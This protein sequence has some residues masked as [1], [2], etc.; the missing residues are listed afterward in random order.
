MLPVAD[1]KIDD[2]NIA[3]EERETI[4]IASS[5][6]SALESALAAWEAAKDKP[7]EFA[8]KFG[9]YAK[10]RDSLAEWLTLMLRAK[11]NGDGLK[12]RQ[13]RLRDFI[14]ICRDYEEGL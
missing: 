14:R 6:I 13:G 2:S 3:E 11:D 10:F 8:E 7:E 4:R 12:A 1:N 5:T 9:R